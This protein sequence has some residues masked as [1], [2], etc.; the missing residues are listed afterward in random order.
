MSD[1]ETEV[2][3]KFIGETSDVQKSITKV[4]NL[5]KQLNTQANK[6]TKIDD[7]TRKVVQKAEKERQRVEK[8]LGPK[9]AQIMK[10]ET[11]NL[12]AQ[13]KA[14]REITKEKKAQNK[15]DKTTTYPN[16][17][18]P[19]KPKPDPNNKKGDW[20]TG[21]AMAAGAMAIK[22]LATLVAMPFKAIGELQDQQRAYRQ[23]LSSIAG[24][25]GGGATMESTKAARKYSAK[26]GYTPDEVIAATAS[27]AR[28]TGSGS[29]KSVTDNLSI[30][31]LLTQSTG[32]TAGM[33]GVQAQAGQ[34]A[35]GQFNQIKRAIAAGMVTGLDKARLPE[36]LSGVSELT[37]AASGRAGGN[38]DSSNYAG[39]LATLGRSKQSG[40]QGARGASV[41]KSLESGFT[42]PGGGEEGQAMVMSA[43]GFG[44]GG[45]TSY[46]GAKKAMEQGSAG[47]SGFI[48]KVMDYTNKTYGNKEE[49][50]LATQQML[51]GSLT[52]D[53]IEKVQGAF[54]AGGSKK[55]MDAMIA[56]MNKSE[57][58][59]LR[60]IRAL[61]GHKNPLMTEAQS[62]SDI[63]NQNLDASEKGYKALKDIQEVFRT[64]MLS[65]MPQ[66]NQ[67][68][69]D[70]AG[71]MKEN[72]GAL[73]AVASA[74][75]AVLEWA[76]GGF[77]VLHN[78]SVAESNQTN[79][80]AEEDARRLRR[81][82]DNAVLARGS[83]SLA[84]LETARTTDFS[85]NPVA[86]VPDLESAAQSIIRDPGA[87]GD[88]D[89]GKT[90]TIL[91]EMLVALRGQREANRT[92]GSDGRINSVDEY[93]K[94]LGILSMS[95]QVTLPTTLRNTISRN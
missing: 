26:L 58:D 77:G 37:A 28:A 43:M 93:G 88:T 87:R 10:A 34:G 64:F 78:A 85:G 7:K 59:V 62:S 67:V 33:F 1:S 92:L 8:T 36:F 47:D 50:N 48:K 57:L 23:N 17:P 90:L 72:A 65:I 9:K 51:G 74:V 20:G 32:E 45:G 82:A 80:V 25:G 44:T 52:L 76:H 81:D 84:S 12:L 95:N 70:L 56:D 53:Q 42:S 14:M 41:L 71:F 63:A 30:S 66:I 15:I 40:L 94:V 83:T 61:L 69:V 39:L 6:Q 21:V 38:V 5:S 27:Q 68:L 31:R 24:Y 3:V 91:E 19:E 16:K 13:A 4:S 75:N 49:A 79:S 86:G 60:D 18:K 11:A 73:K 2:K 29:T 46:Y 35:A 89:A 55:D 54:A 22:A